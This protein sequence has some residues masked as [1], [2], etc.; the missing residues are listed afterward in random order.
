MPLNSIEGYERLGEHLSKIDASLAK[1]A[2]TH[3]YIVYP[4]LSGGRYPNRR[5]TQEGSVFR[6]IHI[7]MELAPNG[8]HFDEFF[9]EIPYS[10]W[11]G[12]WIDDHT[13]QKRWNGPFICIKRI[14]F[15]EFVQVLDLHLNHCHNY[16]S[17]VTE[18]YIRACNSTSF[19]APVP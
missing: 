13:H 17:K 6:S 4:K 19:L 14:P 8:E 2:A 5:I 11:G 12:T 9:P 3:G 18:N 16:L 10:C 7:T 1:F 15:S